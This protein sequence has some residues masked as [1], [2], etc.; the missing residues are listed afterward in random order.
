M[1]CDTGQVSSDAERKNESSLPSGRP[2]GWSW[3][4]AGAWGGEHLKGKEMVLKTSSGTSGFRPEPSP[5]ADISPIAP[6]VS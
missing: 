1:E 5:V 3:C 6:G 4:P 2:W